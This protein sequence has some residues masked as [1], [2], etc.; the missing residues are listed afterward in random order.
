MLQTGRGDHFKTCAVH[1]YVQKNQRD[2]DKVL[3]FKS[4]REKSGSCSEGG[5]GDSAPWLCDVGLQHSGQ[6]QGQRK[7]VVGVSVE[8]VELNRELAKLKRGF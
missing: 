4:V 3:R 5:D 1:A 6:F 8:T 2:P 7:G